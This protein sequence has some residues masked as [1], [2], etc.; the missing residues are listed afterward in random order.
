MTAPLPSPKFPPLTPWRRLLAWLNMLFVDHS[1]FR[2]FFNT[3]QRIAPGCY[4]SSHP[5]PYQLRAAARAGVRSVLSLRGD[6]VHI[7]SN[8]LEIETCRE[9]GLVLAHQPIGSRDPPERHQVVRIK[10][11]F[12]ELP[13]PLLLHCKSG[14]DR[15]GLVSAMYLLVEEKQPIEVA[16]RQLSFWR[17]GHVHQAKTG[18]LDHFLEC[19]RDHYRAHGT[20]FMEWIER[21]Y[22][23]DAVRASFHSSWWANKLVDTVLRRE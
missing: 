12:D 10:Q 19:Y 20:P 22:D 11:L 3:R 4:R 15:A 13:R 18:V 7:G 5:M 16:M 23:R 9:L 17:H 14:A 8:V 1:I 6:E 21:D 2:F